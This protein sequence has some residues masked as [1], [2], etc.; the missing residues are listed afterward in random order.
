MSATVDI[1]QALRL[2][3]CPPWCDGHA[4]PDG[5]YEDFDGLHVEHVS[6]MDRR[7]AAFDPVPREGREGMIFISRRDFH[8]LAGATHVRATEVLFN[9]IS[10]DNAEEA[11][12]MAADLRDAATKMRLEV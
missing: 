7:L 2:M 8:D 10:L 11:D 5:V 12:A 4:D 3:P 9:L 1:D 6:R